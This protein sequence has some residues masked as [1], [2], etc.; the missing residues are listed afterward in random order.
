M[1]YWNATLQDDCYLIAAD[2][3][4]AGSKP[5]EIVKV[6]DKNNKLTWPE[7]HDYEIGKRRF[8]S[9][10]IPAALLI[11]RYFEAE[12]QAIE[13]LE[14][15]LAAT[16]QQLDEQR[17]EQGGEDGLLAEVVEGEGDRQKSPPRP[18]RPV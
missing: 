18:S 5:R 3:W 17:E 4:Q 10:L 12:R 8:K 15:E 14:A 16:E 9:D 2:G 13:A 11:A 6:K 7:P 1:D